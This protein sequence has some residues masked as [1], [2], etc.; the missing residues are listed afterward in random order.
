MWESRR[1]LGESTASVALLVVALGSVL[2]AQTARD[3]VAHAPKSRSQQI[4]A[5]ASIPAQ[6]ARA[7]IPLAASASSGLLVNLYPATPTVCSIS[8]STLSLHAAGTCMI[9]ANQAGNQSYA[10]A[11]MVTQR[12]VVAANTSAP[13]LFDIEEAGTVLQQAYP[14]ITDQPPSLCP[15]PTIV[16]VSPNFWVAGK[17]YQVTI[18]GTGFTSPENATES[19]PV[20]WF[21]AGSDSETLLNTTILN[22]TTA[23]GTVAT[24]E[25]AQGGTAVIQVWYLPPPDDVEPNLPPNPEL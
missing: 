24:A 11:P 5:F 3:P 14:Q 18:R 25:N 21:T 1:R 8:G 15:R 22:A 13:G 7:V 20:P 12:L 6:R 4:I 19:C 17:S 9:R 10:P 16:S 2:P 23:I